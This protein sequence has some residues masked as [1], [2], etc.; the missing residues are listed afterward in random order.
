MFNHAFVARK[1]AEGA[2]Y[3]GL[4]AFSNALQRC[5]RHLY[6]TTIA[7]SGVC[8]EGEMAFSSG[9]IAALEKGCIGEALLHDDDGDFYLGEVCKSTSTLYILTIYQF[10]R[11]RRGSRE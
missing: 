1:T 8:I 10:S 3:F 2:T 11:T 7:E 9:V 6:P 4:P 5:R